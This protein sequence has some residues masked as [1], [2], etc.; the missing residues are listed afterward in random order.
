MLSLNV[1]LKN[2]WTVFPNNNNSN[3]SL[4]HIFAKATC[5]SYLIFK[6]WKWRLKADSSEKSWR[7]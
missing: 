6:G 5:N 2:T 7:N 4:G 3:K 1:Y